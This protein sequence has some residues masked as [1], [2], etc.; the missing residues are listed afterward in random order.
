[1]ITFVTTRAHAYTVAALGEDFGAPLPPCRAMPYDELFGLPAL[2]GGTY[3]FCDI[4]RLSHQELV[5]AAELYRRLKGVQGFRVLNDPSRIRTRYGLLRALREAGVNGFDAYRADGLPKPGA[6]PVFVRAEAVH[7]EALTGLLGSQAELDAELERL[8]GEGHALRGLL[9]IEYR[10]EPV[11]PGIFQRW[12]SFRIGERIH[13]DHIVMED[14]WNVKWGTAGLATEET[15][16]AHDR[17]VRE[18]GHAAALAT[19]FGISGIEY[20]RADFGLVAG[21]PQIYEINTNPFV[22]RLSE[23]RSATRMATMLFSHQR[24][25]ECLAQI[26]TPDCGASLTVDASSLSEFARRAHDEL[27]ETHCPGP[28]EARPPGG[29]QDDGPAVADGRDAEIGALR[30]ETG[31]LRAETVE[32]RGR[33]EALHRSRS[34]RLTGPLR[35]VTTALRGP[36]RSAAVAPRRVSV[37]ICMLR[38]AVDLVPF[39]CG[40]YLRIGLDE[41]RF[42]DDGS[43]DGTY[44]WL[45]AISRR[46]ARIQIRRAPRD[47]S[48]QQAR[49]MTD[50]ANAAIA[51][52]FRLILPF[53]GDEFWNLRRED[54]ETI[55]GD[56]SPRILRGQWVNFAQR[57]SAGRTSPGSLFGLQY[58]VPQTPLS[59]VEVGG[60]REPFIA[61]L[62]HKVAVMTD[63]PIRLTSG[64]HAL[65]AGPAE[66]ESRGFEIFHLPLRSRSEL[67]KRASLEP[68]RVGTRD[69]PLDSWQ[70]TFHADMVREGRTDEVWAANS[71]DRQ[72]YLDVY[73]RRRPTIRDRRLSRALWSASLYMLRRHGLVVV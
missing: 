53:D 7:E 32:L 73:G 40:H 70:S 61:H 55:L 68:R 43:T 67:A 8:A 12:G 71:V 14:S 51:D 30:I 45:D 28:A 26:D 37:A 4:E 59:H 2:P 49:E 15:F 25:A 20:G 47:D 13:L 10:A 58:R 44:E 11:S 57:R 41:I 31:R 21:L 24:F 34:W 64:Q 36:G 1:M 27:A 52:G 22:T 19:A 18:N 54:V 69:H 48:I 56:R 38:D 35:A 17:A 16:A 62:D 5:L 33:I 66:V 29:G 42:I 39:L 6:F 60:F 46:D 63:G 9:V 50:T 23:H 72:G 65:E 3:V